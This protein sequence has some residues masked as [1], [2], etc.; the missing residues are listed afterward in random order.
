MTGAAFFDLDRTL[1]PHASG[2]IFGKYLEAEG[3]GTRASKIPGAELMV[4]IYDLLGETR[5]NMQIAQLA[6]KAAKGWSVA[7]TERAARNSVP[8][9]LAAIPG[10]AKLLLEEHRAA[11]V[12][13]VI[14]STTPVVLM[15]P[16]ADALGFDDVIGTVWAHDGESFVGKTDGPFVWGTKKRDAIVEWADEHD[17]LLSTCFGYSDSYYDTPMLDVVGTAVAVNPDARL[18][19]VAALQ[20]WEIRNFDAPPGVLKFAGKEI[21][22][23]L[24]PFSREEFAPMATWEFSGLENIPS[25]GPAILA[26]NHRSYFDTMA[27]NLLIARTGRPCRF[28]GKAE[29]FENPILGPIARLA[30]GIRVD[31][32]SG[33]SEPLRKA[34]DALNAG[35]MVTLAPQGTIPRGHAFFEPVLVGRPGVAELAKDSK[36]PVIP[37]GLWGT[38]KVWPRNRKAPSLDVRNRPHVSVTVGPAVDVKRRSV[39]ADTKRIMASISALLPEEANERHS[40]TNDELAKTYPAGHKLGQDSPGHRS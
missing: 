15:Q 11:G 26:F 19:A 18:A 16:L 14:A 12:K 2:T 24:R 23:W 5:L 29:M 21:Q 7:A 36:A 22:D 31:R 6:V 40:P 25:E 20:G 30:G 35:E 4:S 1:L 34:V 10:Y 32:G 13:L 37:I 39:D 27:M 3:L 33:S 8:D 28:L 38:E 17:V 9:L